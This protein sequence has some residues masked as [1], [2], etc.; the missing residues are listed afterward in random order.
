MSGQPVSIKEIRESLAQKSLAPRKS[1]GQNFLSDRNIL[2]KIAKV[3]ELTENDWVLEIG[4]GLGALTERLLVESGQVVAI[5]YDR[6]LFSILKE[7]LNSPKLTLINSDFMEVDLNVLIKESA[8]QDK[9]FKVI[10]NLPYYITSPIIF[11]LLES[12]IKWE[13][14][15]LLLQKEVAQRISAKPG[16]KEYGAL[17]VMVNYFG[18]AELVGIVPKTVFYP[19]PQVDSAI[20][21]ITRHQSETDSAVYSYLQKVVQAAF[22]QRRK[23]I[24]NALGTFESFFGGKE[25]LSDFLQ[26]IE[27]DPKQRGETLG[28]SQFLEV[29]SELR[30]RFRGN[31][32]ELY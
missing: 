2:D 17:T 9:C 6:G 21:K 26:K 30:R 28:L 14:L 31:G 5:E 11:K 7:T 10:A 16:S 29:A 18:R 12:G 13:R 32:D 27:V 15:V 3:G 20:I 4:P 22:G 1:L 25:K 24:L 23:T 8:K 19:A